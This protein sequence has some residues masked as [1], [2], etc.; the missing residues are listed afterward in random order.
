MLWRLRGLLGLDVPSA[1]GYYTRMVKAASSRT[2]GAHRSGRDA[3]QGAPRKEA[4]MELTLAMVVL[5][6]LV[7]ATR[8]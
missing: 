4:A 7:L 2:V 8:R 5:L 3:P 6:L 1:K